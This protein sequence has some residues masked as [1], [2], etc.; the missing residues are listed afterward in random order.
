MVGHEVGVSSDGRLAYL[1]LY[2]DAGVGR[3]GTDGQ[4]MLVID[5]A[6]RKIVDRV[7]FGHGVR[8]HCVLYERRSGLLYVTT[9]LDHAITIV[10]PRTLKA[11]GIPTQ[12]EQSQQTSVLAQCRSWI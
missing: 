2:G 10:D 1:P 4:L 6:S 7:D 12:Q 3:P 11:V 9:E 5:I 8:P